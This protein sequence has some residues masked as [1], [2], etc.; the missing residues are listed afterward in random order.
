MAEENRSLT[1]RDYEEVLKRIN[2][3]MAARVILDVQGE[4]QEVHVLSGPGRAPKYIVRDVESSLIAA[5]G[6]PVDRRKI[7]V[8]Q[9]GLDESPRQEKR[10]QLQKVEIIS[11]L[12]VARVNVYLKLG[13]ASVTGT[14]TGSP[15]SA[16]W[17]RC[18][19]EATCAAL[20]QLLPANISLN[21]E[22]ASIQTTRSSR[23]ALVSVVMTERGHEQVL[24]GSC[25]V[26]YDD[27]EAVVK[28][29]LDAVNR[30][31]SIVLSGD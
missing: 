4:I 10:V 28:A 3:V 20:S 21:V 26:S 2:G 30:K 5:F 19:A 7:S 18:S 16:G 27:R 13:N 6:K 8:A 1:P 24:T 25:P 23:V 11:E 14:M 17:L 29:T 22:D 31:L 12:G 9:I 15:T